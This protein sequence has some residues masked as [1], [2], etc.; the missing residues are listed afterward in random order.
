MVGVA[1]W[2]YFLT[3]ASEP[4]LSN[5]DDVQ[6]EI[7]GLKVSKAQG[8]KYIPKTALVHLPKRAVS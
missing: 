5:P 8:P 6:V 4:K 3:P 7:R 1:L 2:S